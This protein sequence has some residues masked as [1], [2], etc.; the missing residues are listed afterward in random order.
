MDAIAETRAVWSTATVNDFPD[1]NFLYIKPG[2]KKDSEGKTTPRD[3]R[4]FPYKNANG[5]VDLPHL[6]NALARIPQSNLPSDVKASLTKKAQKILSQHSGEKSAPEVELRYLVAPLTHVDVRDPTAN[7][8]NTWT[9]SGYAAVYNTETTLH[10]GRFVR[11]TETIDPAAFDEVLRSQPL[12]QP[13]GVVHFNYGHD[14]SSA[15]AATDVPQGQ[16]G[17]LQLR[18]D[19]HGLYFMA[20][21]ARDDPDAIRMASKMQ[22]GVVKQASFAFTIAEK[23][24]AVSDLDDGR[25]HEADRILRV[26]RLYDV[27]ATPQGAYPQTVSQLRSYAA[28]IGQPQEWGGHPRQ[29]DLGGESLVSPTREARVARPRL[30]ADLIRRRERLLKNR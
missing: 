19:A 26:G 5:E 11:V 21:V 16:P 24:T 18:S 14:M 9:M 6:R 23:D 22:T 20:R 10:D 7:D 4:M 27:C 1:G 2:G 17:S 3:L 30:S 25:S 12:G 8:D 28:A 29:P 15:V 13:G